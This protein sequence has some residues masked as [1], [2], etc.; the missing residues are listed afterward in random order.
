MKEDKIEELFKELEGRFDTEEPRVD[1][2]NRFLEKLQQKES[3]KLRRLH[4]WKP[5]SIAASVI[6]IITVALTRNSDPELKDLA[7][8]SPEMEKTQQFF[9]ATISKELFEI[10]EK[11]TPATQQLVDDA[12]IRLEALENE[13]MNLKNDLTNSGED[14]RVI[15]AMIENFQ[16]RI[17]LLQQ[18]LE[19]IDAIYTLNTLQP[20]AL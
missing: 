16:N 2:R 13:Y 9:T 7:D 15:Y 1:H 4:W 3:K 18:V 8:I 14:K 12:I 6:L 10:Q 19:Q 5:I 20:S 11:A 17:N